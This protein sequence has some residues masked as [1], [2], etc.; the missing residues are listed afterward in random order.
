M[1]RISNPGGRL[2]ASVQKTQRAE[3][4]RALRVCNGN[5]TKT[6]EYLGIERSSLY[7]LVNKLGIDIQAERKQIERT[8]RS[9]MGTK[10]TASSWLTDAA[11]EARNGDE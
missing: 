9:G 7:A 6:A 2:R 10:T 3:I 11:Q 1:P 5:T 4:L 8:E